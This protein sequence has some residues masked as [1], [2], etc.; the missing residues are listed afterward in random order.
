MTPLVHTP[1]KS[2]AASLA[3]P[4]IE[5]V[6]GQSLQEPEQTS[7][8]RDRPLGIALRNL[9]GDRAVKP[10]AAGEAA[11]WLVGV[12]EPTRLRVQ[13][14]HSPGEHLVICG[15]DL[16]LVQVSLCMK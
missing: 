2:S 12:P 8:R 9:V 6:P 16:R 4:A 5:C 13:G 14:L 11:R 7:D 3:R 15:A 1:R 10:R